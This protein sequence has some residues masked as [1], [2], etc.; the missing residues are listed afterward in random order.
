MWWENP[1]VKII[2]NTDSQINCEMNPFFSLTRQ[3]IPNRIYLQEVIII[4]LELIFI[5]AGKSPS[6]K[7]ALTKFFYLL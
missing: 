1:Y 4:N 6:K 7:N 3:A 2:K 5:D